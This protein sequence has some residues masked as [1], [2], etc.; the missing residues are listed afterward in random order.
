MGD[1][2]GY[3]AITA[4]LPTMTTGGV[5]GNCTTETGIQATKTKPYVQGGSLCA[6]VPKAGLCLVW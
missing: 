4:I 1:S 6:D 5:Q 3:T 2:G